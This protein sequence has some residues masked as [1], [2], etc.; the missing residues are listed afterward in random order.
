LKKVDGVPDI[1]LEPTTDIL[2][3][4]GRHKPA[5]QILV[6]FAAETERV[7]EH[8]AEKLKRKQ[9]DLMVANDVSQPDA[10]FEVD[11]NRALLL[12][13]AGSVEATALLS[14]RELADRILDRVVA[15]RISS[16]PRTS[17]RNTP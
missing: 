17:E 13:S 12:D 10:G 16:A 11:T 1:V 14:K 5:G 7:E 8:A 15:L 4:L 6:G 3:A 2:A 9:L